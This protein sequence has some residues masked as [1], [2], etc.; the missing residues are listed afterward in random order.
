[1]PSVVDTIERVHRVLALLDACEGTDAAWFAE[2][3]RIWLAG[4]PFESAQG[5]EG[6]WRDYL[7][8]RRQQAALRSILAA[9]PPMPS[10]S[11]AARR[12]EALL[13]CY[14]TTG[15]RSD[16]PAGRRPIGVNGAAFDYLQAGGPTS[17]E[18]LRKIIPALVT[19][20]LAL[21]SAAA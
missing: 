18:R 14:E 17:F 21:T 3:V 1:M 12:V 9:Q 8:Q 16:H 6:S 10:A 7:N 4:A 13:K 15:W 19:E 11:A 5:L 20:T 2:A